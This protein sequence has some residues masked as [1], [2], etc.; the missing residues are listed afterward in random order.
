MEPERFSREELALLRSLTEHGVRFLIVGLSSAALQGAPVVTQDVD[1]WVSELGS[2]NFLSSL[3][4]VG[5]FYIAPGVA[6][7]NPPMIGPEAFRLFDLVID[8]HGAGTFEEEYAKAF[9]V[10]IGDVT[11]KLL[12]LE[13]IIKSK[14]SLGRLKDQASLPALKAALAVIK[15][16]S[17]S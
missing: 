8:V 6:G 9:E 12:S 10:K 4:K 2:T 17:Q 7:T 14:E 1:L 15:S 11:L 3:K 13:S 16:K 5:A